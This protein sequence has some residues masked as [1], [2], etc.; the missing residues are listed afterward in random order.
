MVCV[1]GKPAC[2][3]CPLQSSCAFAVLFE[4]LPP[5]DGQEPGSRPHPYVLFA[6]RRGTSDRAVLEVTLFASAFPWTGHIIY[7]LIEMGR[8]GIG[9]EVLRFAVTSI[10]DLNSDTVLLTHETSQM[11][12]C[13]NHAASM[14]PCGDTSPVSLDITLLAPAHPRAGDLDHTT[15]S[16]RS[17]RAALIRLWL[18]ARR[19]GTTHGT[20]DLRIL[21]QLCEPAR[22]VIAE[23][24]WSEQRRFSGRQRQTVSLGGVTGHARFADVPRDIARLLATAGTIGIG[25]H[26]TMGCGRYECIIQN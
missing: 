22:V 16:G 17:G 9:R 8:Q 1:T 7:A 18:L 4:N 6:W 13:P 25:K 19:H 2:G 26:T 5:G 3:G 10:V 14:A 21:T 12:A 23:Y 11:A 24:D 20:L 15:R